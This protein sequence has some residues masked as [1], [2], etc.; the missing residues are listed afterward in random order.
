MIGII[1]VV[2]DLLLAKLGKRL[3]PWEK[4]QVKV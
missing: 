1:G 2:S 3:F 4:E